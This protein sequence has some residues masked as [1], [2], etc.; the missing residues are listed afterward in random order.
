MTDGAGRGSVEFYTRA[1]CHLC[2][3]ALRIVAA[4]CAAAG[5]EYT[6]I[7]V[8][9]DPGLRERYGEYVPVVVVDGAQVGYWRIDPARLRAALRPPE[10]AP[11]RWRRRRPPRG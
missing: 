4:E 5:R 11:G 3:Q 6:R 10:K 9:E 8:D 2:D 1:G 7:D